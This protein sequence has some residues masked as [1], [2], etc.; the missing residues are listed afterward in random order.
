MLTTLIGPPIKKTSTV[1]QA[2]LNQT[3]VQD[4]RGGLSVATIIEY[5]HLWDHLEA[6]VF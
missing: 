5:L 4:I 1:Q 3:W 6:F 2:L